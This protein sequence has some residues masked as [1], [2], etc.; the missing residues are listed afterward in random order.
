MIEKMM[1]W[2]ISSAEHNKAVCIG[3]TRLSSLARNV[4]ALVGLVSF[5]IKS[6]TA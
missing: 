5:S 1:Q 2:V 4:D 3:H 6:A